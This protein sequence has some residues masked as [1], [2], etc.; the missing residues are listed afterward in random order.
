MVL[1]S[2]VF[3]EAIDELSNGVPVTFCLQPERRGRKYVTKAM[4]THNR[5]GKRKLVRR[6]YFPGCPCD[7]R[8]Q[9]KS[10][11]SNKKA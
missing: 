9:S 8:S 2:A 1:T 4:V 11:L 3:G 10:V 6:S 5:A 7:I